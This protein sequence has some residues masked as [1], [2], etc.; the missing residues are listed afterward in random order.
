MRKHFENLLR[1]KGKLL[2]HNM[3]TTFSSPTWVFEENLDILAFSPPTCIF[4][5]SLDILASI[6]DDTATKEYA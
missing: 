5:D 6:V 2:P 1:K 4:E 3:D